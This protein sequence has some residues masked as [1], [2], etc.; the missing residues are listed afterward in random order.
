MTV[1]VSKTLAISNQHCTSR[2]RPQRTYSNA[3][4]C[5]CMLVSAGKC[6]RAPRSI[7]QSLEIK[8]VPW[9]ARKIEEGL[10]KNETV[11]SA[12]TGQPGDHD[13]RGK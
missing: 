8:L 6:S 10:R 1:I 2:R 9:I 7:Y 4:T 11:K 5:R 13:P 3:M 12:P